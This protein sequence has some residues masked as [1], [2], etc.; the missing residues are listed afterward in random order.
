MLP[1]S[2]PDIQVLTLLLLATLS[3]IATQGF[4]MQLRT[5]AFATMISIF[6]CILIDGHLNYSR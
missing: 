4:C 2:R 5:V 6:L 3:G 1:A